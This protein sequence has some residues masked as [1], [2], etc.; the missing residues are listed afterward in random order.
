MTSRAVAGAARPHGVAMR[1]RQANVY[2][3]NHYGHAFYEEL[4]R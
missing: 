3:V 4:T 1:D 2:W